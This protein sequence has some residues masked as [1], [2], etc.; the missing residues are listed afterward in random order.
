MGEELG[1][2]IQLRRSELGM[3]QARLAELVGRSP[4]TI[5]SWEKGRTS[6]AP[7]VMGTLSD[8]LGL[9]A[10]NLTP[11]SDAGIAKHDP[12]D[13]DILN[14]IEMISLPPQEMSAIG[15]PSVIDL[16]AASK[17]RPIPAPKPELIEPE[18]MKPEPVPVA[19]A[20]PMWE[21]PTPQATVSFVDKPKWSFRFFGR[22]GATVVLLGVLAIV[23]KWAASGFLEIVKGVLASIKAALG[24]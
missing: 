10:E 1:K 6:P 16:A 7:D 21:A 3:S 23:G 24:F 5:R 15:S 22:I 4:S 14:P 12:S 2:L 11:P 17:T 19:T 8:V 9:E 18:L 20:E 13:E